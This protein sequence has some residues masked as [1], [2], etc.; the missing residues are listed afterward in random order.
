MIEDKQ[1][2][3]QNLIAN[4]F[5]KGISSCAAEF[6]EIKIKR[7]T[8]DHYLKRIYTLTQQYGIY[9]IE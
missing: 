5:E 7:Q 4:L 1:S 6:P 3:C 2:F 8:F 9:T